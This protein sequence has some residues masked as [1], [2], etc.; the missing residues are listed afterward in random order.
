M[1][2]WCLQNRE[3]RHQIPVFPRAIVAIL[4]PLKLFLSLPFRKL[5]ERFGKIAIAKLKSGSKGHQ[6]L[7]AYD[8]PAF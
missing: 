3:N 6:V 7:S 4:Q 1:A 2:F 5:P 8:D